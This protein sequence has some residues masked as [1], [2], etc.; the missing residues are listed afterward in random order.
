MGF[1]F[2][3]NMKKIKQVNN[4]RIY[5][6][7]QFP[8]DSCKY[9]GKAYLVKTP[10]GKFIEQFGSYPLALTFCAMTKDFTKR[11]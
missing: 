2:F 1:I 3:G 11:K 9:V 4:L 8:P 7:E 5:E 10:D 6:Y